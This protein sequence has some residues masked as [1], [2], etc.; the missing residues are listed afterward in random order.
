[1]KICKDCKRPMVEMAKAKES[2]TNVM[3]YHVLT[4]MEWLQV[5]SEMSTRMI[6]IGLREDWEDE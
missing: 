3:G 4:A 2:L 6:N 5:L 1:M